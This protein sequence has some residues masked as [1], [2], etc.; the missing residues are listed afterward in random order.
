MRLQ[1]L[2]H[3]LRVN[4][5]SD[6]SDQV[7][8]ASDQLWSD[9][10]LVMYISEAQRRFARL[11]Q[12]LR[13]SRTPLCCQVQLVAGQDT[14]QLHPSVIGVLSAKVTGSNSDLVRADHNAFNEPPVLDNE[15]YFD[16]DV[17]AAPQPQ[18]I[19]AY[20]TDEGILPDD[21]GELSVI[22]L[23]VFPAP[24]ILNAKVLNLRVIRLP[25]DDLRVDDLD[26]DLEIPAIHQLE[27]LDW[28]A[29]LALRHVDVDRGDQK[30]AAA[31]AQSFQDHVDKALE[32]LR[33]KQYAPMGWRFG[34]AGWSYT[35]GPGYGK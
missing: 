1:D 16:P 27:I 12:V 24:D 32:T 10:T 15:M 26:A 2:L 21:D 13:D 20:S 4:M 6:K 19:R 35:R 23:R 30:S 22:T 33:V 3:E 8:G 29:Y 11:A 14:Y 31:F 18:M 34:G 9:Q 25:M 28:A 5:L 17:V 7:G